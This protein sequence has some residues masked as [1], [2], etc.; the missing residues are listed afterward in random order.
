MIHIT[1]I[2]AKPEGEK[3]YRLID[4]S[5]SYASRYYPLPA[6]LRQA[7]QHLKPLPSDYFLVPHPTSPRKRLPPDQF[8]QYIWDNIIN[9]KARKKHIPYKKSRIQHLIKQTVMNN[10]SSCAFEEDELLFLCGK[11]PESTAGLYYCDFGAEGELYRLSSLQDRWLS[12]YVLP[13]RE[14]KTEDGNWVE[15][16]EKR[17]GK[18]QRGKTLDTSYHFYRDPVPQ[19]YVISD[20][21]SSFVISSNP[22]K[23]LTATIDLSIIP[24]CKP[25]GPSD[26]ESQLEAELSDMLVFRLC[27]NRGLSAIIN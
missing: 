15:K 10:L 20:K 22:G 19:K 8:L 26:T 21:E 18:G 14:E 27:A 23:A 25:E 1:K 9:V 3:K 7:F 17:N 6:I 4:I 11:R 13:V 2:C 5:D 16:R 12:K 24:I